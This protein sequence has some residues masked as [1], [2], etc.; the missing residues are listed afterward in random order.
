MTTLGLYVRP[1]ELEVRILFLQEA[2][3]DLVSGH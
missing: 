3:I 2:A 1:L